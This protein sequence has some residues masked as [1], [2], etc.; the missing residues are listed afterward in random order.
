MKW[1]MTKVSSIVLF[2]VGLILIICDIK[3]HFLSITIDCFTSGLTIIGFVLTILIFFQ[4]IG[5]NTKFMKN[6]FKYNK[7]KEFTWL[8][9]CVL[10]FAFLSC[11]L[12]IFENTVVKQIAFYS[13]IISIC[14]LVGVAISMILIIKYNNMTESD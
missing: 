3:Y 11:I 12:N 6:I 8:C 14:E 4:G 9:I 2:L 7:D 13:L 5:R 10:F 1:F